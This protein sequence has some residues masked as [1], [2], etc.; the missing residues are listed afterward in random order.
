[1]KKRN[2]NTSSS[3]NNNIFDLLKHPICI[4]DNNGELSYRNNSFKQLFETDESDIRLDISHP[5]YPEYRKKI[6]LTYSRVNKGLDGRCFAIMISSNGYRLPVEMHLYPLIENENVSSILAFMKIVD[7]RLLS[8]DKTTSS[9]LKDSSSDTKLYEFS[10]FPIVRFNPSGE[11]IKGSATFETLMGKNLNDKNKKENLLF[12]SLSPYDNKRM[13]KAITNILNGV[14][15]FSRIGE[16]KI[17]TANGDEKW[18]NAILYP[19]TD[20]NNDISAIEIILEDF[21][22]VKILE[23]KLRVMKRTRIIGDISI[24]LLHYFNDIIYS[25]TKRIQILK[26]E[27]RKDTSLN[28]LDEIERKAFE[29]EKQIKKIQNFII[30]GNLSEDHRIRSFKKIIDE[31]ISFAKIKFMTENN[32]KGKSIKYEKRYYSNSRVK[33]DIRK[34]NEI[35]ISMIFK[36]SSII[37]NKGVIIISLRNNG[38]LS[39]SMSVEKANEM[40]IDNTDTISPQFPDIDVRYSAQGMNIKIIEEE[41]TNSYSIKAIIPSSLIISKEGESTADLNNL[42]DMNAIILKEGGA[43]ASKEIIN[44]IGNTFF[45]NTLDEAISHYHKE[46]C[47]LLITDYHQSGVNGLELFTRIKELDENVLSV[48]LY[49]DNPDDLKAYRNV[50]DILIPTPLEQNRFNKEITKTLNSRKT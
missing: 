17:T 48:L 7:D 46:H 41:S 34:L 8:F 25:I 40:E 19:I 14:I 35:I 16:L 18:V 28:V 42:K 5:F 10:P 20:D 29:G 15:S 37:D 9:L 3:V 50:I 13:G 4:I 44:N 11:I 31:A 38:A 36:V 27:I 22:Q 47:D 24:G 30:E 39:L 23:N 12:L 45:C 43:V 26:M 1:M 6:A 2:T 21:T 49:N 32:G 33:G